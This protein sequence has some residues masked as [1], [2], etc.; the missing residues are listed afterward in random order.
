MP[1]A[2]KQTHY[3][4][5]VSLVDVSGYPTTALARQA[6]HSQKLLELIVQ[7]PERGVVSHMLLGGDRYPNIL[8]NQSFQIMGNLNVSNHQRIDA[9][10]AN[11]WSLK[12]VCD[13]NAM[14]P[15]DGSLVYVSLVYQR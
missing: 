6:T 9:S 14:I 10:F 1:S 13:K 15:I 8:V 12:C 5:A 4:C 7:G 2:H 11:H 3:C